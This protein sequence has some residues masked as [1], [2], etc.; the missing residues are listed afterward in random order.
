M[1]IRDLHNGNVVI[2]VL[3]SGERGRTYRLLQARLSSDEIAAIRNALDRRTEGRRIETASWIPG[4][5]WRGTPYQAIS[6]KGAR[7]NRIRRTDVWLDG[8]GRRSSAMKRTGTR[9]GGEEI[10]SGSISSRTAE[11]QF[12]LSRNCSRVTT[13]P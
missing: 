3:Q 2:G 11:A 6:E 1:T 7:M 5:D 10:A 13:N 9:S 4:S 8:L 12:C